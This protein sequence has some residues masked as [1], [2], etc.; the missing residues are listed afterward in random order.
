MAAGK[1]SRAYAILRG[2][3]DKVPDLTS[4]WANNRAEYNKKHFIELDRAQAM[5]RYPPS[6]KVG[7]D[8][9]PERYP[10]WVGEGEQRVPHPRAGEIVMIPSAL[11]SI[12]GQAW[13]EAGHKVRLPEDPSTGE[14]IA[15]IFDQALEVGED[16]VYRLLALFTMSNLDVTAAW[17]AGDLNDRLQ[18]RVDWLLDTAYVDQ[19]MEVA[20]SCGGLG[21]APV[22]GE[23]RRPRDRAGD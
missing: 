9:Q 12:S 13:A 14:Q 2:L 20:V 7:D 19:L 17:K 11:D 5:L 6:V 22:M 21:G 3:S 4:A 18:Q 1:Q 10:D 16:H 15:A 23:G 8:G